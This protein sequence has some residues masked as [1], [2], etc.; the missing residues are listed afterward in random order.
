M[1]FLK[2]IEAVFDNYTGRQLAAFYTQKI[3]DYLI[4]LF[5]SIESR[6]PITLIAIG[7]YGRAELAPYSDIDVMFFAENKADSKKVEAIL[8][9]LWDAGLT[10][11]HCYRTPDE[12]LSEAKKDL[13]TY[14]SLLEARFIAGDKDL[15]N[16]FIK[17]IYSALAYRKQ[18]NFIKTKLK[19]MEKRHIDYGGSVFLLEPNIK[20]CQGGLRDIHT[21]LWLAKIAFRIKGIDE[22]SQLISF[23]DQRRLI[24]AYDFL[25]KIR[26]CLHL[27][28]KRRNDVLSFD[29]HQHVSEKLGFHDSKK[30]VGSERFMRYLYLKANVVKDIT[31]VIVGICTRQWLGDT[32]SKYNFRK[33]RITDNFCIYKDVIIHTASGNLERK[34]EWVIEAFYVYA[35]TGKKFSYLLKN[36]L[37]RSLLNINKQLRNSQKAANFFFEIFRSNRIYETLREMHDTGVLGRYIP[38]F[39]ALKSLVV[40]EPYHRYTVDEHTLLAIKHLEQLNATKYKRLEHLS[41]VMSNIK[42]KESLFMSLLFHDIGKA[43]GKYHEK[44]GYKRL[45]SIIDR[46]NLNT[47]QRQRIEFL[48]K[49]H[50]LM[51]NFSLK[52]EI[53]DPEVIAQF[54][55]AVGD[56]MNLSLLY[57]MTY[58]DMAAV[59][60]VFWTEW[61]AYLLNDLYKKT[62]KYLRGVREDPDVYIDTVLSTL[63]EADKDNMAIFLRNM[64]E[65]YLLTTTAAEKISEDF[66]LAKMVKDEN[67]AVSIDEK[68]DGTTELTIGAWDCAGLFSKIVGFLSSKWLNILRAKLYTGRNGLVIDKIQISNWKELWWNGMDDF[69]KKGL[70]EVVLEDKPINITN[71]KKEVTTKFETFIELDNE[72][73]EEN[74]II[75]FY[76]EDRLGLLYDVS[77]LFYEKGLNIVSAKINTES[78]IAHD[79]FYVQRRNNNDTF[80]TLELMGTLWE[81]LKE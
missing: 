43:A 50:T 65:G 47:E 59:N 24:S 11:G 63:G 77:K 33:K 66:K 61:K 23:H 20:E 58:A 28:S 34:H 40:Y 5:N 64:P 74:T 60:P 38:E 35:K 1:E 70:R 26:F 32:E 72:L 25:L 53:D 21:L 73:S 19:E 29:I 37:K 56:E 45:K 2:E 7:G 68:P 51:S 57:L 55:D 46:L 22:F 44:E 75:E 17:N 54:A 15:Y 52:R 71:R 42:N 78:G 9:K 18:K 3:D 48:V 36:D 27:I 39:G 81:I 6:E 10:V 14:T 4:K 12:C 16:Y 79:I 62:L 49:N 67:F 80:K 41:E 76:S 69:I 31:S 30:F 8:Y 13:R